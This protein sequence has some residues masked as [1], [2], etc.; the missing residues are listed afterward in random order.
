M[1]K[2]ILFVLIPLLAVLAF[3]PSGQSK[4]KSYYSGD[5][6][7]F[8]DDL[9]VSSANSG[10]LEILKL[11]ANDLRLISSSKVFDPRFNRY[12]EFF[13]SK[14]VVE[15]NHLY[16]YAISGFSL[17]KYEIVNDKS[18]VLIQ[19]QKNTYWEWYNRVDKFGD[20][21]ITVSAKG[22][23]IWNKDLQ[24]IDSFNVT[25]LKTPYNIRSNNNLNILDVQ[26]NH[27]TVFNRDSRTSSVS[28]PLNYKDKVGN[29]QA[30]QD[31]YNDLYVVDDY[32]AKKFNAKGKLLAS[33]K[34][35]DQPGFDISASPVT[36]YIYFS[37]GSGVVKLNKDS[38][39]EVT[40]AWTGG[41]GGP[42][43]WAMGL[44]TVYA[45]GDKV[46]VFNNSNI[47]V[48]NSNLKKIASYTATA[49][50]LEYSTENL[51][52]N[53]NHNSGLALATVELNGGGYFPNE[54]L[55][56]NFGG[57]ETNTKADNRGRFQVNL[58]IPEISATI[59]NGATDIKVVGQDSKLSYSI[60]FRVV[61]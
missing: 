25:N 12:D 53:L 13:D 48:L 27:L 55:L 34:H 19:E 1:K 21:I 18:L 28:I 4:T 60:S 50:E 7:S 14:L 56:I 23:K 38:L 33:F 41:L 32:Y 16:V 40:Y 42:R 43:G 29:R 24:V 5:A 35:I 47:L 9:Y 45:N 26:D 58:T 61:K 22:V 6:V 30:Y 44:K 2:I 10:S 37:N 3:I 46:V 17:Y 59:N 49:E 52:L 39:E 54:K 20:N 51:Y 11:E 15:N 31:E 8:N 36:N 57:V